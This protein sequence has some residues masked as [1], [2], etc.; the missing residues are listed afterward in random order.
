MQALY[1]K[2]YHLIFIILYKKFSR[3]NI[4]YDT[5]CL[6]FIIFNKEAGPGK[7]R[8]AWIIEMLK[9]LISDD[10][11]FIREKL[12]QFMNFIKEISEVLAEFTPE[13]LII[14]C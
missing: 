1:L 9:R 8:P 3:M 11:I 10:S 7:E 5:L 6:Q 4:W 14:F 13:I 12:K 2:T